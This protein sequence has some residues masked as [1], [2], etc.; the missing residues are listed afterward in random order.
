MATHTMTINA[1]SYSLIAE[2][3]KTLEVRLK[4][5]GVEHYKPGDTIIVKDRETGATIEKRIVSLET[6]ASLDDLIVHED[7]KQN[8]NFTEHDA[9]RERIRAFQT[10]D[11]ERE[12]GLAAIHFG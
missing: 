1:L 2:G 9:F 3:N 6:Y 11:E 8:G 4:K 12:F 5:D 7:L 10:E